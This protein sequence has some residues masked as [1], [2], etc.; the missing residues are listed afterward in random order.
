[1]ANEIEKNEFEN[2][3]PVIYPLV[4]DEG[5]VYNFEAL[6]ECEYKENTYYALA[7]V[8]GPETEGYVIMRVEE[9]DEEDYIDLVPVEDDEEFDAVA[10]IFDDLFLSDLDFD[11]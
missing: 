5:N 8:D 10:E 7:P 1:M 9:T 4:D 3:E 11:A 2:A 6:G